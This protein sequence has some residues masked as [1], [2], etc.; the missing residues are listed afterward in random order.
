MLA[1]SF[2]VSATSPPHYWDANHYRGKGRGKSLQGKGEGKIITGERGGAKGKG[3]GK[4]K[5][6]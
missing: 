5:K 6:R 4:I 1:F 2:S 3:E